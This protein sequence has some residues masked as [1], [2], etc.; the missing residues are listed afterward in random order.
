MR[1][2]PYFEA[3][4]RKVHYLQD[5]VP[6]GNFARLLSYVLYFPSL[7]WLGTGSRRTA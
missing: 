6:C 4:K 3:S 5:V 2:G 1:R 7:A